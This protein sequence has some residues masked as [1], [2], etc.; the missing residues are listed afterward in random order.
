MPQTTNIGLLIKNRKLLRFVAKPIWHVQ[1]LQP[2]MKRS[3]SFGHYKY[4][5]ATNR[6]TVTFTR[7][8]TSNLPHS[9]DPTASTSLQNL[10]WLWL[11]KIVGLALTKF[12]PGATNR[13]PCSWPLQSAMNREFLPAFAKFYPLKCKI[14]LIHIDSYRKVAKTLQRNSPRLV[15]LFLFCRVEMF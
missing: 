12:L 6:S 3:G 15:E 1:K 11:R 10:H 4:I 13:L 7:Q 14:A 9:F 5:W 8:Y 2:Q